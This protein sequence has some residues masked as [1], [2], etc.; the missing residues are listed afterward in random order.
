MDLSYRLELKELTRDAASQKERLQN[1][2][3]GLRSRI[4]FIQ[5]EDKRKAELLA[6]KRNK[7]DEVNVAP[8]EKTKVQERQYSSKAGQARLDHFILTRDADLE[9][10]NALLDNVPR[11]F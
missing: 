3:G 7:Q 9:K 4:E 6:G 8:N 5:C 2:C 10:F 11:K 1:E